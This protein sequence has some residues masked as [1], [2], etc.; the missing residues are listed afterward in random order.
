[1]RRVPVID[2]EQHLARISAEGIRDQSTVLVDLG[3]RTAERA[4]LRSERAASAAPATDLGWRVQAVPGTSLLL[5]LWSHRLDAVV[6]VE[7]DLLF[8]KR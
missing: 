2:C 7:T 6:R 8:G 1:M 4:R 3:R 5:L